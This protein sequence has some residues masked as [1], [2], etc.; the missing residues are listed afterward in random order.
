MNVENNTIEV[1]CYECYTLK[2]VR[3]FKSLQLFI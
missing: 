3:I 2:G 1:E